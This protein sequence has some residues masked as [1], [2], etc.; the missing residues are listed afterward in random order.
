MSRRARPGR[1][2][3]DRS[4]AEGQAGGS[5]LDLR[6]VGPGIAV[7]A[8]CAVASQLIGVHVAALSPLVV[9][10]ILGALV[11]NIGR[12]RSTFE[13]GADLVAHHG[14]RIGI[15]L[16]GFRLS[17]SDAAEIGASGLVL[18]LG[19]VAVTFVAVMALG[20]LLGLSAGLT[21]L[22]A[23]GYAICGV[24]AIAAMRGVVDADEEEVSY[25]MG[26]VTLSGTLAIVV[27]PLLA[28]PL[29]LDPEAFGSW[30]GASV[31]DVGQV[32]ATA[33][34]NGPDALQAATVVK[35]TRV[36]LLGPLVAA[37]GIARRRARTAQPGQRVALVPWFVMAFC[38]AIA[39][40]TTGI[41]PEQALEVIRAGEVLLFVLALAGLGMG[42]HAAQ[43]RALG[44]RPLIFGLASWLVIGAASLGGL[45]LLSP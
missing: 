7:A 22:T 13:P 9:A 17:P 3:E 32:I 10:V 37:M 34:T 23:T 2:L 44:T 38:A 21:T 41:I 42:V 45:Q 31:H 43:L 33:S 11:V 28:G 30:V 35:L 8:V 25:A 5:G 1:E 20:R 14:L 6:R 36:A 18:V 15:V 4:S 29:D 12:H 27:L 16:L 26:L 39:L 24:S 40:R 19:V